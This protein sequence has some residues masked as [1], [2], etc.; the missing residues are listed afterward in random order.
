M[1]PLM[2]PSEQL[3]FKTCC[4]VQSNLGIYAESRWIEVFRDNTD[5]H[6]WVATDRQGQSPHIHTHTHTHTHT[7]NTHTNTN[8]DTYT[9]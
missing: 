8:T 5:I 3:R 7:Q 4:G 2:L 6:T 9:H 1:L